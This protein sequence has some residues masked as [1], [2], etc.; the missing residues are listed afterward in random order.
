MEIANTKTNP[1][2][3]IKRIPWKQEWDNV[4]IECVKKTPTN[5]VYALTSASKQ[6]HRTFSCTNS[7]YY[8]KLRKDPKVKAIT[9]GS[10]KGFTQNVK[11]IHVD[12][13]GIMPDQN[14]KGYMFIMREMLDL[15]P[16][17]RKKIISFFK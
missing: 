4:I 17:D 15:S 2:V 3:K 16:E 7:R 1:S 13:N 6:I 5:I 10:S 11:N 9:C 12:D 14:L 8:L